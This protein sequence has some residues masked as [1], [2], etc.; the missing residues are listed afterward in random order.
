MMK[1]QRSNGG[2]DP[3]KW[4]AFAVG[5]IGL[6]I[7]FSLFVSSEHRETAVTY[8]GS[9]FSSKPS[10]NIDP[11]PFMGPIA[12]SAIHSRMQLEYT[13]NGAV[14]VTEAFYNDYVPD[15]ALPVWT[16]QI[17]DQWVGLVK[18]KNTDFGTYGKQAIVDIMSAFEAHPVKGK[19]VLVV[20]SISP[21]AEAIVLAYGAKQVYT[22]DFNKPVCDDPRIITMDIAELDASTMTYDVV[23]SY[24][25]L[26]HDGLGRFGDPMH[27]YGDVERVKRIK[28][29]V[30]KEGGLFYLAVPTGQDH[31]AFNAHRVSFRISVL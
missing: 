13:M 28:T 21:W 16:T 24:S 27:P 1:S 9:Q 25:S 14:P 29:L 5:L 15:A 10:F 23:L 19:T 17:I 4:V 2:I 3:R 18:A 7:V 22:V 8:L 20:G 6:F 26:E 11:Y 30:K 31:L 12:W